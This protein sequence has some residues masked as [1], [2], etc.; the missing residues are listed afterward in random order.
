M[1]SKPAIGL[2][3]S[4]GGPRG[5]A[6]IGVI[7]ALE[8]LGIRPVVVAGTSAGSIIGAFLAAGKTWREIA[9]IAAETRWVELFNDRTLVQ[10]CEKHLPGTF[11]ELVLPFIAVAAEWKPRRAVPMREGTLATAV[12]AS[13]AIPGVIGAVKRDGV[14]LF[15]G[16]LA[17]GLPSRY[18]R[19]LGA[20]YVISSDVMGISST[21]RAVGLDPRDSRVKRYLPKQYREAVEE[22][23]VLVFPQIP[24]AGMVPGADGLEKMI[25]AGEE[26]A[27]AALELPLRETA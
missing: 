17:C 26:A 22:S 18:A 13:C 12:A 7:K 6:H 10:Y 14:K 2:A 15:D 8:E 20:T 25:L 1:A 4:G 11:A 16:G 24:M 23:D 5:L 21:L 19:E 9:D 3:L 27:R